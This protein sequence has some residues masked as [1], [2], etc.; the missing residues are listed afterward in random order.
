MKYLTYWLSFAAYM[1]LHAMRMSYSFS[2]PSIQKHF[3]LS[4]AFMGMI[5]AVVYCSAGIG[6][7]S[8]FFINGKCEP[9]K[10]YFISSTLCAIMFMI[11]PLM[12]YLS[13]SD[14]TGITPL[15]AKAAIIVVM[16]LFGFC[17][18]NSWPAMLLL[19]N[20]YFNAEKESAALGF[21]GACGDAGNIVG[22]F[23]A[24]LAVYTFKCSWEVPM[25]IFGISS[26]LLAICVF[27]LLKL[28]DTA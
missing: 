26:L 9:L 23:V 10:G 8:R 3:H 14:Y 18:L 15:W 19:V 1:S 11:L 4:N 16:C 13:N 28:K 21:W 5:D 25:F 12:G 20:E 2:K 27:K 24:S 6:L 17:Q 7:I 22:F